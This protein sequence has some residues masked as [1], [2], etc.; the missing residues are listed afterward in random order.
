MKIMTVVMHKRL[1][2]IKTAADYLS[3]GM[4]LLYKWLTVCRNPT[5]FSETGQKELG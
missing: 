5:L 4:T 2:D 3:I 1:L